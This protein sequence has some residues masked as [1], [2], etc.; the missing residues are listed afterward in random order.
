M[1][2]G[3]EHKS[4]ACIQPIVPCTTIQICNKPSGCDTSTSFPWLLFHGANIEWNSQRFKLSNLIVLCVRSRLSA[5]IDLKNASQIANSMQKW[6]SSREAEMRSKEVVF[7]ALLKSNNKVDRFELGVRIRCFQLMLTTAAIDNRLSPYGS[8]AW[9]FDYEFLVFYWHF[10]FLIQ[11][12]AIWF[13]FNKTNVPFPC[14]WHLLHSGKME[15]YE[16]DVSVWNSIQFYNHWKVIRT[17][18]Q[19]ATDQIAFTFQIVSNYK[20][21]NS[22]RKCALFVFVPFG[23]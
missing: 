15:L 23:K 22:E 13:T 9:D 18:F 6:A 19:T 17:A 11:H 4:I 2:F 16:R 20:C 3:I 8:C 21:E 7:V 14:L 5:E 10:F 1:I 12:F